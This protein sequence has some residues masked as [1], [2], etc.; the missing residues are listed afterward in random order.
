VARRWPGTAPSGLGR[1]R[2]ALGGGRPLDPGAEQPVELL[3][4]GCAAAGLQ[5]D[6]ELLADGAEHPL[7]LAA[8]LRLAGTRVDKA[9][10]E[11][12]Q[13]ALE[14]AGDE[15][16]AVVDVQG[17]GQP[18]GGEPSAQ[19]GLQPE[20]VFG[21]CPAVADQAAGVVVDGGKQVGLAAGHGRAVQ[22]IGGPQLVGGLGLEPPEG[23]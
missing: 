10:P 19:R 5:L 3:Q 18:A 2:R 12:R 6:Q 4:V 14:L 22:R 21:S 1:S 23:A 15:R 7:D 11:H 20:G 16:R 17:A 9:D 8:A 13:A